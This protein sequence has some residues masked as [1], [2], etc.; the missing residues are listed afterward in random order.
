LAE[1]GVA[2]SVA[3]QLRLVEAYAGN[4]LAL[5]IVA[6]TIVELFGG[7]IAPF[8]E[9]GEV[10]FGGVRALLDEQYA[11]LSAVEQSVLLWLAI[12][13]EPVNLQE[14]LPVLGAPLPQPQ[15][16]EAIDS[17]RGRTLIE[18]GELQGSVTLQ[19]MVMEYVTARIIG[20][21][22]GEIMQGH[23]MRL[24]VAG[25]ELAALLECWLQ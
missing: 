17:L 18:R 1:K 23:F 14:L 22:P 5:K 21:V 8:L 3:E 4:P 20:E 7:Q 13:R 16:L 19:S 10:V 25:W 2:G 24:V 11:R 12:L 9:Q 6:R 15:V